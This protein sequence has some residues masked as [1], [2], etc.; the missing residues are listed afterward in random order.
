[1]SIAI[2]E[3]GIIYLRYPTREQSAKICGDDQ[4][5]WHVYHG[6]RKCAVPIKAIPNWLG[7]K[8]SGSDVYKRHSSCVVMWIVTGADRIG[9]SG[10]LSATCHCTHSPRRLGFKSLPSSRSSFRGTLG[11]LAWKR[12]WSTSKEKAMPWSRCTDQP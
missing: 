12:I 10:S 11:A 4:M 7:L 3:T 1:M 8:Q 6:S 2:S 9:Y 5:I